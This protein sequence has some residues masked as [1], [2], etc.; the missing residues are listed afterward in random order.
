VQVDGNEARPRVTYDMRDRVVWTSELE[1]YFMHT[2]ELLAQS[3][4][5]LHHVK[6][7]NLLNRMAVPGLKYSQLQR[8][9]CSTCS[10]ACLPAHWRMSAAALLCL[11]C[12]CDFAVLTATEAGFIL[13]TLLLLCRSQAARQHGNFQ[14][15]PIVA[16]CSTGQEHAAAAPSRG[17]AEAHHLPNDPADHVATVAA[18]QRSP[19]DSEATLSGSPP[20]GPRKQH[21]AAGAA[22]G[23]NVIASGG[24]HS[25]VDSEA[26]LSGSPPVG[27][28]KQYQAAGT[29]AGVDAMPNGWQALAPAADP[30]NND[31]RAPTSKA[32]VGASL[33]AG[34]GGRRHRRHGGCRHFTGRTRQAD[35]SQPRPQR[36][37]EQRS[38]DGRQQREWQWGRGGAK[39]RA[40]CAATQVQ[41]PCLQVQQTRKRRQE[42]RLHAAR[43]KCSVP[44]LR[45]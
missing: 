15:W 1:A 41:T 3:L 24:R 9:R 6:P 33:L 26:T 38:S 18:G 34:A 27:P 19:V 43:A 40:P 8:Y 13:A 30:V 21:A 37:G 28:G 31:S 20:V 45:R 39:R 32:P 44:P 29:S 16:A 35:G 42:Q 11:I 22:A 10:Y 14:R 17:A 25:P 36:S 7:G 4:G 2:V 23:N 5:G 12:R